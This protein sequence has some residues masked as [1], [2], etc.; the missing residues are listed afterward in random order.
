MTS[1]ATHGGALL[2]HFLPSRL[3]EGLYY[4]DGQIQDEVYVYGSFLQSR[5]HAAGVTC[6]DCHDRHAGRR[7]H[8][9]TISQ[10]QTNAFPIYRFSWHGIGSAHRMFAWCNRAIRAEPLAHG[11]YEYLSLELYLAWRGRGL[12]VEVPAIRR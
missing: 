2:D 7:L 9:E 12:T 11:S 6:S 1:V 5:M 10:G 4:P 3:G 8:G